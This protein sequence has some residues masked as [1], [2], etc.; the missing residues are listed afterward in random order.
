M[1][2]ET[3]REVKDMITCPDCG[4]EF[5]NQQGLAGHARFRH[6]KAGTMRWIPN[7]DGHLVTLQE[8]LAE[9]A[10]LV[11]N[12]IEADEKVQE[13]VRALNQTDHDFFLKA[14]ESNHQD[15][16]EIRGHIMKLIEDQKKMLEFIDAVNAD[17]VQLKATS[18]QQ[19][20]TIEQQ[21]VSIDELT[22]ANTDLAEV[23]NDLVARKYGTEEART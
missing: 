7:P 19:Q 16:H 4:K 2:W 11:S 18:E 1:T 5:K 6:H 14:V 20:A 17:L 8:L 22:A 12:A 23:V 9:F 3:R 21:Q 15:C 10:T 13:S